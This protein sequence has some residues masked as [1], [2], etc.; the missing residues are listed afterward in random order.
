[1][2]VDV[3]ILIVHTF[4]A[5]L[6]RQTLRGIRRAAPRLQY[7]I[8]VMDNNPGAGLYA[9]LRRDFPGVRYIPM[10]ANRGFGYAMNAG[11]A[12]STGKYV[13]IFNPDIIVSP[14]ALEA[15]HAFMEANPDVGTVG[16]RLDNPDGSLQHSCYRFHTPMIPVYRRTP[17]G[18]L[19]RG[20]RA[21]ARFLMIDDPHDAVM[22]VD[23]IMGSAMFTRRDALAKVGTFDDAIF[24]YLEDTDLCR[25]LWEGGWRVVY[26]PL[27]RMV[28]YHRRAS[29]DGSLL[30]QLFS[31][32][33]RH[34]I[35]SA[36]YYFRKYHGK[37]DPRRSRSAASPSSAA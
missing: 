2:S 23:W 22:D 1:M 14:G 5:N 37:P 20:K 27:V 32:M 33:T 3:S 21:V 13:L 15:L 16:P 11:I 4:E 9:H 12:A 34:H 8:L 35:R 31:R 36:I 17:L 18:M 7:E 24:L 25:R 26:N 10:D 19:P 30:A 6:V 28:H 29:G